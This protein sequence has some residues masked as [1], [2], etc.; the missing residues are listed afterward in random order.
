MRLLW[1][2]LLAVSLLPTVAA[3][4][5]STASSD[6]MLFITNINDQ[7]YSIACFHEGSVASTFCAIEEVSQTC[8]PTGNHHLDQVAAALQDFYETYV[9]LVYDPPQECLL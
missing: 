3:G 2:F 8:V 4:T 9:C 7:D 5:D 1:T 6:C